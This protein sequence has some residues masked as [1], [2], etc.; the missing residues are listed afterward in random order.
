[1]SINLGRGSLVFSL[2]T[3]ISRIL[4]FIRDM[5]TAFLFG[6]TAGYEAFILAFRIPNLLRRMFAEGAFAQAFI[7]V[8]SEYREKEEFE[9]QRRFISIITGNL[10]VVLL[11][12]T[13]LGII[14]SPYIIELFAPGFENT[15]PRFAIASSMLRVTFAYILFISL[16]ALAGSILNSYG[17]FA[18]PA[19]A[20]MLLNICM[21]TACFY[22]SPKL[23]IPEMA[24][25]YAVMV[26]GVLQLGLQVPFLLKR[27]LFPRIK[28]N[29]QDKGV[30]KVLKL[31]GP[32]LLGASVSQL[33]LLIDTV[34]ASFLTTGS[35]A[36]LYY[37]E[38]LMEFP[39]GIFGV[40]FVTVL[41]PSLS[42]AASVKDL[43]QFK[44]IFNWGVRSVL[45]VGMP[46]MFGLYWL[47]GPILSTL[48][49]T[50]GKFGPQD[51]TAAA[52][53]LMAYSIAILSMMLAKL[54][55]SAF[56]ARQEIKT[57]VKVSIV[58]LFANIGLNALLVGSLGHMG[59]ALATSIASI[60]NAVILF[61]LLNK[62]VGT[63]L[64]SGIGVYF[65][66]LLLANTSM[67]WFLYKFTP[68][69]SKWLYDMSR[70]EK[71]YTLM[72]L[73]LVGASIYGIVLFSLKIRPRDF[74]HLRVQA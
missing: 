23:H 8:L 50:G 9:E 47:S 55:S 3:F 52:S 60:I 39:L 18:A 21:V 68:D 22:L 73:V 54:F 63:I 56:Y 31:M 65:L 40:S 43:V 69:F 57:P 12:I 1:M 2:M 70:L 16:T 37:S 19:A 35:I 46:S 25:A 32:A 17:H 48:F 29:W 5:V 51:V 42:R 24:L 33:N 64:E 27:R 28:I 38:R 41:L 13:V 34:F 67:M 11:V 71:I 36:W 62:K 6:A 15:D 74:L 20:P 66:K 49:Q 14:F 61:V 59:L 4:G 44:K 53:S 26:A 30:R 7:P 72:P 10:I 45:L 58:V